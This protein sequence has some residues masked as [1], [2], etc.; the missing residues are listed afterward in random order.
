MLESRGSSSRWS[1]SGE[2]SET[3][4]ARCTAFGRLDLLLRIPPRLQQRAPEHHRLRRAR[5][6]PTAEP[7]AAMSTPSSTSAQARSPTSEYWS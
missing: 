1:A 3:A 7:V 4:R 5:R 6:L 2:Y